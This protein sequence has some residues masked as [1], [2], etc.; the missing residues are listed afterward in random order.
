INIT[1]GTSGQIEW[2]LNSTDS[3]PV[4]AEI[5][6]LI[7]ND[8]TNATATDVGI[9]NPNATGTQNFY[10]EIGGGE[11][12]SVR[13]HIALVEHISIAGVDTT[14]TIP[15]FRFNGAPTGTIS[16]T[17]L[18]VEFSLETNEFAQCRYGSTPDTS[19]FSIGN[20]FSTVYTTIH[21]AEIA[22]ATSTT[23][24]FYIRCIDDEGNRN[25]DDYV[26]TFDVP[27]YPEGIPGNEGTA[28][29][30]GSGTGD[31]SGEADPGAGDP[32]GGDDTSGG[33][34]GGGG[35][36]GS[37]GGT[38]PSS[39]GNDG[40]GGFEGT[41]KPYQSGDGRV[42]INGYAFPDSDVVVL[43]DG[44]KAEQDRA[45]GTGN[46][47]VILDEIARGVYTFGVYAVDDNGVK[48]STF[49]TTFTVTGGRGSTLSNVNIM[50]SILVDPDP[51]TP[52][53]TVT[54]TGFS[55]PDATLTIE[56]QSDRSSVT[57]KTFTTTSDGTGEWSL[58]VDT[59]G[60]TT[61]TYKVRA[62][63]K[64]DGGAST[65]YSD[66]TYYGVG[67]EADRPR[68][69]DLNRDGFVNLIDFSILLFW[70]NSDGGAS[71]PPA[72]I[73]ADGNVSLTDF[74]IMI[75]NWTG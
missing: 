33:T 39:G 27:E 31:G 55:I 28:E 68:N 32:D 29:G 5:R 38:G 37:S 34:S 18:V 70:W 65:D 75:F 30:E 19:Y 12:S 20:Q 56:N 50:P 64:Q 40:A 53:Q 24:T 43:V 17:S 41:D 1:T 7:G 59:T 66:F 73:N 44:A 22:V 21:S 74:S 57:L 35:G 23:Y 42:I 69:P 46:F 4:D 62:K 51:V 47:S 8:T 11:S 45:D 13:G 15:P 48:S 6:M 9:Q 54:F 63:A 14:E 36:G 58:D 25:P 72:D 60:F 2:V 61:G 52:G 71:D 49:S 3:I 10:I 26:I 67:E 16:G